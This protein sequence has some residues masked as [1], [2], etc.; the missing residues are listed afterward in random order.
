MIDVSAGLRLLVRRLI[1]YISEE[2]LA[3]TE[4][5]TQDGGNPRFHVIWK[6]YEDPSDYTW[7]PQE[8]LACV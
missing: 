6:G 2:A 3:N 5:A 8:N 7:E 4:V 1:S